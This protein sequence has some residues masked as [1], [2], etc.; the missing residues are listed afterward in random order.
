VTGVLPIGLFMLVELWTNAKAAEGP[1]AYARALERLQGLPAPGLW[2]LLLLATLGL[3]ALYGL[4]LV[5]GADYNIRRYPYSGNWTYLMQ[6]ASGVLALGFVALHLWR[7]SVPALSGGSPHERHAELVSALSSTWHGVPWLA[8][9]YMVGIGACCLH[10][11][12]GLKSFAVRW[13]LA[14]QRSARVWAGAAATVLAIG[15]F[16]VGAHTVLALAT[17]WRI[18]GEGEVGPA[19]TTCPGASA[20][21]AATAPEASHPNR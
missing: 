9:A 5:I 17:G 19:T 11:G 18:V 8:F 6:R 3:H 14:V 1:E 21:P 2:R 4:Y 12:C 7:S 15:S 10:L 13:G 16:A 20:T